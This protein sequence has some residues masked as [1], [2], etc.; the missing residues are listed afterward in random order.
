VSRSRWFA[1]AGSWG[2]GRG[3]GGGDCRRGCLMR[4]GTAAGAMWVVVDD[5]GAG[6][7]FCDDTG[8]GRC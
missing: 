8:G 2:L 5:G 6:V 3:G 7:D 4:A 1:G